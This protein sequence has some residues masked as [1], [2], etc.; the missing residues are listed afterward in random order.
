MN[1][2]HMLQRCNSDYIT[3][4]LNKLYCHP[5]F[6]EESWAPWHS[7]EWLTQECFFNECINILIF[8]SFG[9]N[10]VCRGSP[11][12]VFVVSQTQYNVGRHS[13][14]YVISHQKI[15]AATQSFLGSVILSMTFPTSFNLQAKKP[16]ISKLLRNRH[17]L[18]SLS[19]KCAY[20]GKVTSSEWNQWL[21]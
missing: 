2:R 7:I 19:C 1:L 12:L 5:F 16:L 13:T 9:T 18:K 14:S 3:L 4:I 10:P 21:S 17:K 15:W 8:V 6:K 20:L 11:S